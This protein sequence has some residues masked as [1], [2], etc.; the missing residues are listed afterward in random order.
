M[1]TMLPRCPAQHRSPS[2][3]ETPYPPAAP[4]PHPGEPDA[5]IST[6]RYHRS[7]IANQGGTVTLTGTRVAGNTPD[8]CE[9]PG[10]I[11]GCTG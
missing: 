5:T 4:T 1:T 10:T 11:P 7:G 2:A 6:S 8:N 9:P 3:D